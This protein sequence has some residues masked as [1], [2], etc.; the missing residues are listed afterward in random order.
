MG[1]ARI[2]GSGEAEAEGANTG[3]EAPL[4]RNEDM[5]VEMDGAPAEFLRERVKKW[6]R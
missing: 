1:I 6:R 5:C 4:S 3:T 2:E